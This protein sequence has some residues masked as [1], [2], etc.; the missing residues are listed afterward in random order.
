MN[1]WK[2]AEYRAD[3]ARE[4]ALKNFMPFL[5]K[6]HG[7]LCPDCPWNGGTIFTRRNDAGEWY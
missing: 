4:G 7:E 2:A 1:P 6:L 5:E 3:E